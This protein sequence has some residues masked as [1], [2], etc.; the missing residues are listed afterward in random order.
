MYVTFAQNIGI[1]TVTRVFSRFVTATTGALLVLMAFFPVV[2]EVVAAIP[3]PVL[4]AA[5]VVMFGTIA[6]VGIR[7]LGKV[8]F[9]RTSNV[10]IVA[11]ALGIALL[12]AT[13]PGFTATFQTQ[14]SSS[15]AAGSLQACASR[16]CSTWCSTGAV[17]LPVRPSAK[18][19]PTPQP[20]LRN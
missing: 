15:S 2:G 12:P 9:S 16:S 19:S 20:H 13:V 5:A 10:I 6:V 4:G 3:R 1:L 14:P 8:D 7:T 11:A 18:T 17:L